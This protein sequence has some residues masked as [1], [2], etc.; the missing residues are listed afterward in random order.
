MLVLLQN[1]TLRQVAKVVVKSNSHL[2]MVFLS[3][4]IDIELQP[5]DVYSIYSDIMDS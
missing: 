4:W 5:N 1:A 3:V 2:V